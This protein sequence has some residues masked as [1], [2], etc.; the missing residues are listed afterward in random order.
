MNKNAL[1]PISQTLNF[2]VVVI[3]GG[4]AGICAAIASA[5]Q[6]AKTALV[7]DRPVLGGNASS[8]IRMHIT[9]ATRHGKAGR[10]NLRE[11]GII[12][13]IL[14]ENKHRNPAHSYGMF[15]ALLWEKC[16]YQENLSLY[17]NTYINE[18]KTENAKIVSVSGTQMSTE[19][20]LTFISKMF[21]DCTG[22]GS[23]SEKSGAEY[24]YGRESSADFD[25]PGAI[26]RTDT[27]TQG[28]T[29]QF[30]SL[31]AGREVPFERP[32]W[33]YDF[34]GEEWVYK[35]SWDWFDSGFWWVELGGTKLNTLTDSEE[36]KEELLKV[37]YGLWDII[38]NH[39]DQAENAKNFYLDWVGFVSAKRETRRVIGDYVLKEQDILSN[40]VFEDAISY[41]G[42][43]IDSHRPECF[44]AHV[45]D[46]PHTE[47]K[48]V[49]F[50]GIYTVPYRS[51]YSKDIENLYLGG[52]CISAT[53]RAFCSTRVMATCAVAG[54]A[55]GIAAAL[56][57]KKG[58]TARQLSE[59]INELQQLILRSGCYI[60]EFK[61]EDKADKARIAHITATSE[62]SEAINV[63]NGISRP[64]GKNSNM[65]EACGTGE[66]LSLKWDK[67]QKISQVELT[68][69]SNLSV[70][71]MIS[72]SKWCHGHQTDGVPDTIVKDYKIEYFLNG[73]VVDTKSVKDNHQR[74]NVLKTQTVCDEIKVTVEQTHGCENARIIEIRAY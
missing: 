50:E 7:Q 69:D 4:M 58:K 34:S 37:V 44:Y 74:V 9:G 42:W 15:D 10:D 56:A 20:Q 1:K 13:E 53:H 59:D 71:I 3:G 52:R 33:A 67:P 36:I 40:K 46:T 55:A 43:H 64:V 27:V 18:V 38:K 21:I 24:L 47:D 2:D 25:E 66:S 17:L 12:E 30:R 5:R 72:L 65:W 31:D 57:V 14:L 26:D 63:I 70:E 16:N 49:M 45:N 6:G 23:I 29:I 68:F 48:T 54:E 51:I 8:E 61:N 35:K 32:S 19:K 28:N 73:K 11:T 39:S 60:P 41:G 62:K 22:D